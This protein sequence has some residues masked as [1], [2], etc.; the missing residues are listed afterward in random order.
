M[1]KS[2]R[3]T[4]FRDQVT[5]E[6]G[7]YFVMGDVNVTG[8]LKI[9]HASVRISGSLDFRNKSMLH[10]DATPIAYQSGTGG[11]ALLCLRKRVTYLIEHILMGNGTILIIHARPYTEP[12]IVT[13]GCVELNGLLQVRPY[14]RC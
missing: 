10:V 6:H 8:E 2:E 5:I 3:S 14:L 12:P 4:T 7:N 1:W 13:R 11:E 9:H